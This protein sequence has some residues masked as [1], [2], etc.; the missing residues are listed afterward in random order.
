[1]SKL[2]GVGPT[3]TGDSL[4]LR[5]DNQLNQ[6]FENQL[7]Q[8]KGVQ[9]IQLGDRL[10]LVDRDQVL[11]LHYGVG[12]TQTQIAARLGLNQSS[13]NRRLSTYSKNLLT[14]LNQVSQPES[15]MAKYIANWLSKNMTSPDYADQLQVALIEIM[16]EINQSNRALLFLHYGQGLNLSQLSQQLKLTE[17][18]LTQRLN[19]IEKHLQDNL[20]KTLEKLTSQYVKQWLSEYYRLP[21]YDCLKQK[22]RGLKSE[23]KEIRSILRYDRRQLTDAEMMQW[24]NMEAQ[25]IQDLVAEGLCTLEESL[26]AWIE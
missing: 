6:V 11:P 24:V 25:Q 19:A 22:F 5:Q 16:K 2:L 13:I 12:F 21:I 8:K 10:W 9:Q 20:C 14:A 17:S 26:V 4:N 1:M 23:V 15:W 7:Q 18:Q 3:E